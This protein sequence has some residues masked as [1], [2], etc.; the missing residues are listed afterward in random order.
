MALEKITYPYEVLI[1]WKD[2]KVSGA[3]YVEASCVLEDGKVLSEQ[4]G[5]AQPIPVERVADF[6]PAA[7]ALADVSR[8]C[9]AVK[10]E[11]SRALEL[12]RERD[13]AVDQVRRA[14]GEKKTA[15]DRVDGL[16][17]QVN[18]ANKAAEKAVRLGKKD[19][20]ARTSADAELRQTNGVLREA[21]KALR[22]TEGEL[23]EKLELLTKTKERLDRMT[24]ENTKLK[25]VVSVQQQE[26]KR[27]S[28]D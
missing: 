1:R 22:E 16:L 23:A 5:M 11:Q 25:E 12:E 6:Y 8:L 18:V 10:F 13:K 3:H 15:E 7:D 27:I 19:Q 2:G 17:Q 14:D 21:Q 9:A 28:S 26:L 24:E 20:D 4:I